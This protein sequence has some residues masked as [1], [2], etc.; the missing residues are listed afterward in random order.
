MRRP[1]FISQSKQRVRCL[2]LQAEERR[3]QSAFSRERNL[4]FDELEEPQR[5]PKTAGT[6][7]LENHCATPSLWAAGVTVT[8]AAK[9]LLSF[10]LQRHDTVEESSTQERDDPEVQTVSI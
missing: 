1:D 4:L 9:S 2:A 5:L 10:S 8:V 6:Q 7:N 3:V